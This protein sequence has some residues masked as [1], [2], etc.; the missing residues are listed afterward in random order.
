MAENLK[1]VKWNKDQDVVRP[2]DKPILATG[3]VVGLKGN[4]APDGAIVNENLEK[5]SVF[6][7]F[8][9]P[10]PLTLRFLAISSIDT[11]S[12]GTNSAPKSSMQP[13]IAEIFR[14][15]ANEISPVCSNR[16]SEASDTP[17]RAAML[18][19]ERFWA[20]RI[21]LARPDT[22]AAMFDGLIRDNI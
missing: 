22:S 19:C 9:H 17:D 13:R 18:R 21:A 12:L 8:A 5:R 6:G 3:G 10:R 1:S 20:N 16:F 15:D 7:L 2:A 14:R 4:L 11:D